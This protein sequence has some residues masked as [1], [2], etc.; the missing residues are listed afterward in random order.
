VSKVSGP[1]DMD[2]VSEFAIH[3]TANAECIQKRHYTECKCKPNFIQTE[4]GLC[5]KKYMERCELD[6]ECDR[7]AKLGCVNSKC[8]CHDMLE[9]YDVQRGRCLGIKGLGI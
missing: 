9:T 6:S 5:V 4:D 1:C 7:V 2:G 8:D 3:C